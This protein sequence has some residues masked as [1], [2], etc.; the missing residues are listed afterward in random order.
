MRRTRNEDE[1]QRVFKCNFC[2]KSYLSYPALY[3]HKKTKHKQQE[4]ASNLGGQVRGRGRPRKNVSQ[5]SLTLKPFPRCD[6]TKDEFYLTPERKG[7]PSNAIT[8]FKEVFKQIL[9]QSERYKSVD[10]YPLF[11][12]LTL[13][14]TARGKRNYSALTE[15][16]R[17]QMLVDE[18]FALY[19]S[20]IAKKLNEPYYKKVLAYV[21]LFRE[22]LNE[23]GWQK[24]ME[25]ESINLDENHAFVQAMKTEEFCLVNTAEH[26]PEIC[27][28]FVRVYMEQNRDL[29]EISKED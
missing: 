29:V 9:G 12:E 27:N 28:E 24:K 15:S 17:N 4:T 20:T 13:M 7:G 6:P 3:T 25:S 5:T 1:E 23:I 26:A 16:D 22:C 10:A 21:I 8:T 2:E 11:R 18:V 14:C 19:L